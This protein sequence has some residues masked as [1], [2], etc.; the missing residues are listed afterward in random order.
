MPVDDWRSESLSHRLLDMFGTVSKPDKTCVS[1]FRSSR[2][3]V[4]VLYHYNV[5]KIL[6][7]SPSDSDSVSDTTAWILLLFLS[8]QRLYA[9]FSETDQ[10][11]LWLREIL[12]QI[13]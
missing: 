7:V 2:L 1:I 4:L 11:V 10:N 9:N 12:T 5:I 13:S 3:L 8:L 6:G